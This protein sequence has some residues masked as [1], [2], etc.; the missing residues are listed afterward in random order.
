MA[1]LLIGAALMPSSVL[2]VWASL[3][4]VAALIT[5]GRATAWS[6]LGGM[7][8][9]AALWAFGRY[10]LVEER[11]PLSWIAAL[12]RRVYV[13]GHET[14]HAL[15]AWASGAKVL[16]ISVGERGGHVDLSHSNA[17]IALAP[18]CVPLYTIL[19]V[20]AYRAL[21]WYDPGAGRRQ[22]FLALMGATLAFH[23][24]KTYE[25]I[26][27]R[28]QPDLPAAGGVLFSL[29]L[30]L[31]ANGLVVLLLVKALFPGSVDL[32]ASLR[33]VADGTRG[34][35]LRLYALAAPLRTSFVAQLQRP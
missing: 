12:S 24:L 6:F 35:W 25:T 16:G 31:L 11:G 14:T 8:A 13:L 7:A 33:G 20:A 30:I 10:G 22:V 34:F 9:V 29:A 5:N 18:Y 4:A 21:L 17:F 23:V 19:V 3:Q 2:L 27:D 28:D 15:A 26:T 32:G 1:R